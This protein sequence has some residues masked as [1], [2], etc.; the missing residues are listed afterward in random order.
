MMVSD[1]FEGP[2]RSLSVSD[3]GSVPVYVSGTYVSP[4]CVVVLEH[5]LTLCLTEVKPVAIVEQSCPDVK[6]LKGGLT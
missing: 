5:A 4:E 3:D 1:I 6:V 2:S